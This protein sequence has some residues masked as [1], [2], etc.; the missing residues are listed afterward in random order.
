MRESI[1]VMLWGEKVGTL[2]STKKGYRSQIYFYFDRNF[3]A[4]GLDIAPLRASINGVA[5]KTGLPIYPEEDKMFSGLPSFIA[6]SMPDHW[7]NI[8]F[9][10]WVKAHGIRQKDLS[11]LD[12]LAYI[13]RR[14][15]GALEFVPPT[16][17]DIE[18]SFK[19]EISQLSELAQKA[20]TEAEDFH[21]LFSPG[22]AIESLFKVGTSAGGRRPKAV[23]N[24]NLETGECYSG[25][26]ATPE[27]DFTPMIIKFDEH[28]DIPTTRIEYSYYL[29]ALAAGLNFMPSSLLECKGEAHFLTER[30]DRRHGEK[31]HVQTLAAMCP[32]ANSYEDLFNVA[33]HLNL[34]PQEMQQL[35]IQMVMNVLAANVDDHNK[36]FSF[37]MNKDGMWHI[38]PAYDFTFTVDSSAPY[39]LNRHSMTINGKNQNI[40]LK[41]LLTIAKHYNIKSASSIINKACEVVKNYREYGLKANV[42]EKWIRKIEAEL[43]ENLGETG[44][45]S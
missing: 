22:L 13:G 44:N 32:I 24:L 19:V 39:Y 1:D 31:I 38:A 6:D 11:A 3:A 2:V 10:E 17:E 28:S 25:Q 23:I 27:P 43:A 12:R 40:S 34:P 37:I 29:M 36:N 21:T 41:D 16:S 42:T 33:Q 4:R 30:F 15:M 45:F 7:G 14:G 20:L 9:N 5:A 18:K 26:V 35:F 8:V